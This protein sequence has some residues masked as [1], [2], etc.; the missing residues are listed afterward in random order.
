M[1]PTD[2]YSYMLIGRNAKG[3]EGV[4]LGVDLDYDEAKSLALNL[5][6]SWRFVEFRYYKPEVSE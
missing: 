4:T 6:N 3:E 2:G 1:I 5:M